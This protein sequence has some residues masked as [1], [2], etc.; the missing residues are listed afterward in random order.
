M[1]AKN[2][3]PFQTQEAP[4]ATTSFP[5]TQ[6]SE[7]IAHLRQ[8]SGSPAWALCGTQESVPLNPRNFP[9]PTH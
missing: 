8:E 5:N 6:G 2:L 1:Q 3:S 7:L 9:H 4:L